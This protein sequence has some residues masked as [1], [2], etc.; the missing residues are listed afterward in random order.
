LSRR[1]SLHMSSFPPKL[2]RDPTAV[3]MTSH[4]GPFLVLS[5]V[6]LVAA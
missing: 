4:A 5:L 6:A 1:G 2:R 3:V